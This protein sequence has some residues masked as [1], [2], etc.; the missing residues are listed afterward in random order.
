MVSLI[1]EMVTS[2]VM[3]T[4]HS[5]ITLSQLHPLHSPPV[6]SHP[7]LH[8]SLSL[9]SGNVSE[10]VFEYKTLNYVVVFTIQKIKSQLLFFIK[11]NSLMRYH[12]LASRVILKK[13]LLQFLMIVHLLMTQV[14]E[15]YL[16]MICSCIRTPELN[17]PGFRSDT[18][19]I[20]TQTKLI[21]GG[22]K[23]LR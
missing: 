12:D 7:L 3:N 6:L 21:Y 20:V 22:K 14:K 16:D 18:M 4:H 10:G 1:L 13:Q 5:H 9:S 15:S 17:V 8:H 11:H 2:P 23:Q 19:V